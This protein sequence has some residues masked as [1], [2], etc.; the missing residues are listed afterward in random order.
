[1]KQANKVD[2]IVHFLFLVNNF[3]LKKHRV[4]EL[5]EVLVKKGNGDET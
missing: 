5:A 1:M 4:L 2:Y 3:W